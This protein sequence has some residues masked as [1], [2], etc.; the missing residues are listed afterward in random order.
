MK[1]ENMNTIYYKFIDAK[2]MNHELKTNEKRDFN[3]GKNE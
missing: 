3:D 1:H 2:W